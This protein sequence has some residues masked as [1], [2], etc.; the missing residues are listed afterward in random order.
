MTAEGGSRKENRVG[1]DEESEPGSQ[2]NL[3]LQVIESQSRA[4]L[5]AEGRA[6]TWSLSTGT[7]LEDETT[8][9]DRVK[10]SRRRTEATLSQP[11][12]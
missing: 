7:V 5:W 12:D 1:G 9:L 4:G 11:R 10:C 3:T 6:V 8:S 2:R